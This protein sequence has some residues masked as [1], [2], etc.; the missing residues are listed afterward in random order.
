[1]RPQG[2]FTQTESLVADV[3]IRIKIVEGIAPRHDER[4]QQSLIQQ[5]QGEQ[6]DE[7]EGQVLFP[8]HR[9]ERLLGSRDD[10]LSQVTKGVVALVRLR[11]RSRHQIV[12]R[13]D[14]IWGQFRHHSQG[15]RVSCDS[16]RDVTHMM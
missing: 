9:D 11:L 14:D 7:D 5:E 3:P 13:V 10:V 16:I 1:M 15:D 4:R 8:A 12:R 6:G 2:Q